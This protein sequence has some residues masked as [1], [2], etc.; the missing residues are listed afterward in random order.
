MK[1]LF[2]MMGG[3]IFLTT[4][5]FT[6]MDM[7]DRL[8]SLEKQMQEISSSN[9][10]ETLG[11]SFRSSRPET[12]NTRFFG[13]FEILYWHP[14]LGGTEYAYTGDYQEIETGKGPFPFP[15]PPK[16]DVKENDLGWDVGLR[17]GL[18]YKTPHNDW[19]VVA[20]YTWYSLHDS[21][22]HQKTYPSNLFSIRSIVVVPCDRVKSHIDI[23]LNNVEM[24]LARSFFLSKNF[25]VRP[26]I[27]AKST[28]ID[29]DQKIHY[30]IS[31]A[32]YIAEE[33]KQHE[34]KI[35]EDCRFWGVGPRA[36][37]DTSLYIGDGFSILGEIAGSILY[38]SFKT[39]MK[40]NFPFPDPEDTHLSTLF[41]VKHRF[42]R[43]IPFV[44]M[45]LGLKWHTYLNDHRQFLQLKLG[46]EAQYYWRVNQMLSVAGAVTD[47]G[48]I[49]QDGE[50]VSV[51][52]ARSAFVPMTEDLSFYGIT[53][54]VR[55][56]F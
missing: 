12:N 50:E 20:R 2:L 1:K 8:D 6:Y 22:S 10:Q 39:S 28:W 17:V 14:K 37:I 40:Q 43:F 55:L 51:F 30:T 5:A 53:G 34:V 56:D 3:A 36:G 4:S 11:A 27:D 41:K 49:T 16:G 24:E 26:H 33:I 7:D 18:G 35:T 21:S 31:T 32:P 13:T 19:D 52:G 48:R 15:L 44:Q 42:H 38:S 25:S 23:D 45:F 29:L 47:S 54:E 9:P 46:Y